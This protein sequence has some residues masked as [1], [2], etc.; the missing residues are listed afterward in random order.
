ML[1]TETRCFIKFQNFGIAVRNVVK[2]VGDAF[3]AMEPAFRQFANHVT[4]LYEE[5]R[6]IRFYQLL[7]AWLPCREQIAQRW[8]KWWL[9]SHHRRVRWIEGEA[10]D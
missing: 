10:D 3:A 2:A 7:P 5:L 4:A 9:P 6:R 8:P 1:S